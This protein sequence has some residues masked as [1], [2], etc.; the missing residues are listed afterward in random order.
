MSR[1]RDWDSATIDLYNTLLK[2]PKHTHC[3]FVL[4]K[5]YKNC[6]GNYAL[7]CIDHDFFLR[8]VSYNDF[9]S[10]KKLGI[11]VVEYTDDKKQT[12]AISFSN[13]PL[14]ARHWS[15]YTKAG[16]PLPATVNVKNLR[17]GKMTALWTLFKN[18]PERDPSLPEYWKFIDSF[19]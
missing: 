18:D 15:G 7:Y 14:Y 10:Y 16:L 6:I 5:S 1:M 3:N 11:N 17:S 2:N 13:S 9:D 8:W 12:N 19:K 4:K